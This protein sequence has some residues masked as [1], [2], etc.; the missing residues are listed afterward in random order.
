MY[1]ILDRSGSMENC[2]D[3]T[4]DGY[5][6]FVKTCNPDDYMSLCLFSDKITVVYDK[7]K[8]C[9][10]VPLT[11]QVYRPAGSTALLDAIGKTIYTAE[12][13]T[14]PPT[15]IIFTDGF[16]NSSKFFTHKAIRSLIDTKKQ[17]G[18]KFVYL[19]ANQD[20]IQVAEQFGIEEEQ[21]LTFS[22]QNIKETFR[23]MTSGMT[24]GYFSQEERIKS[25]PI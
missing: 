1:F 20:A 23:S 17:F 3:E 10:I 22:T 15:I 19:G 25:N 2:I 14:K 8:V 6:E 24:R 21:S 18:W 9:D 7:K 13:S 16:E 11:R 5:N 12:S 4:I